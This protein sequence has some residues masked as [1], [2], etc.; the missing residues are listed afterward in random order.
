MTHD[1]NEDTEG[2]EPADTMRTMWIGRVLGYTGPDQE[3]VSVQWCK[4]KSRNDIHHWVL[5]PLKT[6]MDFVAVC[7]EPVL[8]PAGRA[9][10]GSKVTVHCSNLLTVQPAE[11]FTFDP[12]LPENETVL[13]DFLSSRPDAYQDQ[14]V[15]PLFL[16]RSAPGFRTV[17]TVQNSLTVQKNSPKK[18]LR[19]NNNSV[20]LSDS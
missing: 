19:R 10:V 18:Q 17:V 12:Q 1:G 7:G 4:M 13:I 9:Y 20:E 6:T 14:K 15:D 8:E 5:T 11:L 16:P 3:T 2:V